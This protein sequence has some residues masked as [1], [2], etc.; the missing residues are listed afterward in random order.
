[1]YKNV[2]NTSTIIIINTEP[3]FMQV[4]AR[5]DSID[6]KTRLDKNGLESVLDS[7]EVEISN[8]GL[9]FLNPI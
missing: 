6:L 2:W 5:I 8:F 4:H 1:M 3:N 7:L 9:N